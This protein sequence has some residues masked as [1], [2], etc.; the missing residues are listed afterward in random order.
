[1]ARLKPRVSKHRRNNRKRR[2]TR[3]RLYGGKAPAIN[4]IGYGSD[5]IKLNELLPPK[6]PVSMV[7]DVQKIFYDIYLQI[8]PEAIHPVENYLLK[9]CSKFKYIVTYSPKVLAACKNARRGLY[10]TTWISKADW[11]NLPKKEEL[12]TSITGMADKTVGHKFRRQVYDEQEKIPDT[13]PIKFFRSCS[14]SLQ[15]FGRNPFL[16][17]S[18][19]NAHDDKSAKIQALGSSQFHIVIENS[20]QAN[21]FTEKLCDAL[22]TKNIPIYYGCTNIGDFFDTTGWIIIENEDVDSLYSQ[23]SKLDNAY[24]EANLKTVTKNFDTVMKY[25]SYEQNLNACLKEMPDLF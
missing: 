13:V 21:Y 23:L 24:Y 12:I 10:G 6:Q 16:G 1:M 11:E 15:D 25:I 22:I 19:K 4:L 9:N 2:F 14:S 5:W 18:C 3:K 8:E 7:G 17:K 20:R